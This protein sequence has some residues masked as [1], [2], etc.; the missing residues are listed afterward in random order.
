MTLG[1]GPR[2][3]GEGT[4]HVIPR[5]LNLFCTNGE[6]VEDFED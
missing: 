3:H 4:V 1:G 2:P 6:I 5:N